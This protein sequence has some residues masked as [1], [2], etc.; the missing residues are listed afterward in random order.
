MRPTGWQSRPRWWRPGCRR[1][2]A[3][4][5][6]PSP[7]PAMPPSRPA[8]CR[9]R[10]AGGQPAASSLDDTVGPLKHRARDVH[11]DGACR[12]QVQHHLDARRQLHGHLRGLGA[13]EDAVDEHRQPCLGL[14]D[15]RP[16][17]H[18]VAC[19]GKR[20]PGRDRRLASPQRPGR[21]AVGMAGSHHTGENQHRIGLPA[22]DGT[23]RRIDLD[24]GVRAPV[25]QR[26]A[27]GLRR[28]PR[29]VQLEQL[30]GMRRPAHHGQALEP[31]QQ[32]LHQLDALGYQ[33][34]REVRH[35]GPVHPGAS[36]ALHHLALHRVGAEG[37]HHRF[38]HLRIDE[39][40]HGR[41]GGGHDHLGLT[42]QD[43][44]HQGLELVGRA[45]RPPQVDDQILAL[46]P[47]QLTHGLAPDAQALVRRVR[48]VDR[49]PGHAPHG[50]GADPEVR[51][52]QQHGANGAAAEGGGSP[53]KRLLGL[54]HLHPLPD[55]RTRRPVARSV[56]VDHAVP[57]TTRDTAIGRARPFSWNSPAVS[58]TSP[59]SSSA[60]ATRGATRISPPAASP[61]SRAARLVTLPMAP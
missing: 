57:A 34:E 3:G 50:G 9:R 60:A 11:A 37:E 21:E 61:H 5:P 59:L 53:G 49:H 56:T 10:S 25:L 41:P 39:G 28:L 38:G 54:A 31:R 43:L 26:Q 22:V 23:Q 52:R 4:G 6:A 24:T 13:L 1:G 15:H 36:P 2:P 17:G 27:L 58:T 7:G 33:L 8:R 55:A 51:C 46:D 29:G 45:F 20:C 47:A 35:P 12:L 32:L 42:R 44:R 48:R 40:P 14:A 30:A 19:V 18:Q 16:V